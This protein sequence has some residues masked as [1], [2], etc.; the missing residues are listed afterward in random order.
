MCTAD[1]DPPSLA[2]RMS[3]NRQ[4]IAANRLWQRCLVVAV[5]AVSYGA[6]LGLDVGG[7][8]A[9][10]NGMWSVSPTTLPGHAPRAYVEPVLTP[11]KPYTDAVTVANYTEAPLTFH[12]YGA[13]AINTPGDG[14]SLRRRT[15]VQSDIG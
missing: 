7:A 12:L 9:A 15:D 11:G 14:L 1:R 13:D 4:R 10:S 6:T 5:A 2:Q 8:T 3:T